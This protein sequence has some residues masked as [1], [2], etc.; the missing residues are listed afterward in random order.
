MKLQYAL[1]RARQI[2][3]KLRPHTERVEILGSIRRKKPEVKDI[4]IMC[5]P[6]H[7]VK[8]V[9]F[10]E[11]LKGGRITSFIETVQSLGEIIKG[12]PEDGRYVQI[13]L[14]DGLKVDLFIPQESDYFRQYVIRTGSAEYSKAIIARAWRRRGWVGTE[15]G[16]RRETECQDKGNGEWKCISPDPELPPL[17]KSEIEFYDWLGVT[18]IEPENRH[19]E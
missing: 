1:K 3:Q 19:L 8:R 5:I 14:D 15:D 4:E 13:R 18:W 16:L 9:L 10:G 7:K 6:K 2:Q 11:P 12:S 17:W